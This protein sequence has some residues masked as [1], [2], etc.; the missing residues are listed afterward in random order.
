MTLLQRLGYIHEQT[1][2]LELTLQNMH[3]YSYSAGMYFFFKWG[4]R[5]TDIKILIGKKREGVVSTISIILY[6][7]NKQM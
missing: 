4:E 2:Y 5:Q 1:S 6:F 7:F 3:I